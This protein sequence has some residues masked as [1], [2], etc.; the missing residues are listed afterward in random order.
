MLTI[1]ST[2]LRLAQAPSPGTSFAAA[3][4]ATGG[5]EEASGV[6]LPYHAPGVFATAINLMPGK[7][8]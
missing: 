2:M 5:G 8:G 3:A 4:A 6:Q 7:V 1:V